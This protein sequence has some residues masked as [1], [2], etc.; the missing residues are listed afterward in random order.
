[1]AVVWLMYIKDLMHNPSK[2]HRGWASPCA[3]VQLVL[4]AVAST[5]QAIFVLLSI[6]GCIIFCPKPFVVLGCNVCRFVANNCSVFTNRVLLKPFVVKGLDAFPFWDETPQ[7]GVAYC[8]AF[9]PKPNWAEGCRIFPSWEMLH[10]TCGVANCLNAIGFGAG[11]FYPAHMHTYGVHRFAG[12]NKQ[13]LFVFAAK[14]NIAGPFFGYVN[15]RYFLASGVV[16]GNAVVG[17]V[18]VA[19]FVNRHAVAGFGRKKLF[20]GQAAVGGNVVAVGFPIAHVGHIQVFAVGG[21]YDA[22]GLFNGGVGQLRLVFAGGEVV[23]FFAGYS[24]VGGLSLPVIPLK[25]GVGKVNAAAGCNPQIVGAVQ[26]VALVIFQQ[27]GY[28]TV[29]ANAPQLV[30]LVGTGNKVA[31]GIK[32]HAVGAACAVHKN[33]ELPINIIFPNFVIGLVCEKYIAFFI[34]GGPFGKSKLTGYEH[35]FDTTVKQRL[36]GVGPAENKSGEQR[37]HAARQQR[38]MFFHTRQIIV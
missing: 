3:F 30:V 24:R 14:A 8:L 21:A 12:G 31:L 28:F 32:I 23:Q 2:I 27:H 19:A 10:P 7:S 34:H 4:T 38:G 16:N 26:Q 13:Q 18:N 5:P 6:F 25:V 36:L 33:R 17:K 11:L 29:G 9:S 1:M 35:G 37:E 22:V 20:I 15:V